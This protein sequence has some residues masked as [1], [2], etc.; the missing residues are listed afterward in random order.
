MKNI[1]RLILQRLLMAIPLIIAVSF[2]AFSL[3]KLAGGDA[4]TYMYE[5][6]GINVSEELIE[7]TKAQYG[8]DKP[9]LVQYANWI[10]GFLTGDMGI[11]YVSK[12]D[13]Y[14]SFLE[15]L[16]QTILLT[17]A[18]V[19]VTIVISLP[20]GIICALK[21]NG[22]CDKIIL[23][24]SFIG[25]SMPGFLV[26]LVLMYVFSI[27]L[28]WLPIITNENTAASLILPAITLAIPMSAKYI[29]QIRENVLEELNRPYVVG[30]IARGI[31]FK[32]IVLKDIMK[33]SF[34]SMVTLLSLSIG[35]LLG[36]TAVVETIFMWD[37]IGK[38][39]TDAILIR[40]YPIIL[41]YVVWSA[42]IYVL[43]NLIADIIVMLVDPRVRR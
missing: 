31:S 27:K 10:S 18:S 21:H 11:S 38:M 8:L 24:L 4:I 42:V 36:G 39:A 6:S 7:E 37:G 13:V 16:P 34:T 35:S 20:F 9:F 22:I 33:S 43:V 32:S 23:F 19:I 26:A 17:V 2:L 14:K 29:R 1:I 12:N 5:N 3:M 15:K 25:N 40:D 30:A 28:L 41:A